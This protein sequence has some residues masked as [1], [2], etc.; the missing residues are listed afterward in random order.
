MA[1]AGGNL[2][3]DIEAERKRQE[4]VTGVGSDH[5][6]SSSLLLASLMCVYMQVC[7]HVCV[8]VTFIEGPPGTVLDLLD[9]D[10]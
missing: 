9:Q 10:S 6:W 4:D 3:R 2:L 8:Q 5:F 7:S 1:K